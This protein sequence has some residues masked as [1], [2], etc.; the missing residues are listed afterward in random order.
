MEEF[1]KEDLCDG[2]EDE[3]EETKYCPNDFQKP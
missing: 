2:Y 3:C 1:F